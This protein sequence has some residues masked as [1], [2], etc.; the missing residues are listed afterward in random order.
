M[1]IVEISLIAIAL[2]LDCFTVSITCGIIQRRMGGQVWAMSFLFGLFQ[3]VMALLGWLITDGFSGVIQAYD[4]WVAF[5]ILLLLGAK[6]IWEGFRPNKNQHF[7]PSKISVLLLLSVA[8]SI[9]ALAVGCSFVGMGIRSFS[10]VWFPVFL[11][12]MT[13]FVLSFFGKYIGVK[14]GH[15]LNWPAE[16]IG[17]AILILIGLKILMQHLGW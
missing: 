13:S 10:W 2:G 17:G 4:H 14:I 1:T 6:M 9:D 15:R 7:N 12:G 16:Q 11:I 3:G 8:T 5:S